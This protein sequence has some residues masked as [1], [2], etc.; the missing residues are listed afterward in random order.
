MGQITSQGYNIQSV[1]LFQLPH[2]IRRLLRRL[3]V[4]LQSQA[5]NSKFGASG[6]TSAAADSTV[7]LA[8]RQLG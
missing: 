8:L 2:L 5:L 3:L 7:V 4:G 1:F 6:W